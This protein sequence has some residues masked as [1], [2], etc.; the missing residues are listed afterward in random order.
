[1][2]VFYLENFAAAQKI[3]DQTLAIEPNNWSSQLNQKL[4][5]NGLLRG[6]KSLTEIRQFDEDLIAKRIVDYENPMEHVQDPM[7]NLNDLYEVRLYEAICRGDISPSPK[8]LASLR[9]R[10]V[11]NKLAFLKIAP[12][13]LE[14]ISLDPYII[15]YHDVM[16]DKEID[17]IKNISQPQVYCPNILNLFLTLN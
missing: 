3:N 4:I 10:Y 16:Y 1:M 8:Q 5:E 12:F 13:K 15:L 7:N 17:V 2:A 11:T 6:Q 14:E 9:C